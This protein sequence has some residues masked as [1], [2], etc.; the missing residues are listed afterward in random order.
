[1]YIKKYERIIKNCPACNKEFIA[2]KDHPN[3][4]KSC[5]VRCSNYVCPRVFTEDSKAR[6]AR[7]RV[8]KKYNV[9]CSNATCKK[10]FTS[11]DSKAKFC[12]KICCEIIINLTK[13][14]LFNNRKNWQSARSSIQNLARKIFLKNKE[15]KCYVCSY[16]KHVEIC[17]IKSVSSF[18]D[19]SFIYEINDQSNLIGLCPNHH[20]EFDNGIL[21]IES[22]T[23]GE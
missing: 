16:D 8:Q 23:R 4:Q 12:S 17:H 7:Y 22:L 19:S 14:E 18:D 3:E 9:T 5:S 1:M 20:W 21:L 15:Y 10:S 11:F 6:C 13:S 2:K